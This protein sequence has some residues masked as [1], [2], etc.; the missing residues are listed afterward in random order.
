MVGLSPGHPHTLPQA[1]A[2]TEDFTLEGCEVVASTGPMQGVPA[3]S[4]AAPNGATNASPWS[5]PSAVVSRP[6]GARGASCLQPERNGT[7]VQI[8]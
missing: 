3:P 7:Q 4:C 2:G 5:F 8:P 6:I 1:L